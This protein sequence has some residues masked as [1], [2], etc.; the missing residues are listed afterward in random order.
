M[1]KI[2]IQ[3]T[4]DDQ[5]DLPV[6]TELSRR[7]DAVREKAFERFLNRGASLGS[8]LDDWIAA[9]HE[10]LGWPAAELKERNGTYEVDITLPGY[11]DKEVEV[12]ATPSELIVHAASQHESRGEDAQVV[13]SEFKSND[14]YRR[15]GFPSEV[16]AAKVSAELDRGILKIVAPKQTL[17][18]VA[19]TAATA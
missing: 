17:P 5:R 11:T 4:G 14:V 7:M 18:D 16:D 10:V 13:W 9:E 15:F 12:T 3:R 19:P 1:T 8:D 6:F 2:P